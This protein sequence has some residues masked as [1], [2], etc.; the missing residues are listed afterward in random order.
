MTR[1]FIA[2]MVIAAS[3]WGAVCL[4][5]TTDTPSDAAAAP[6]APPAAP[7]AAT[8]AATPAADK[9]DPFPTPK[10]VPLH[11]ELQVEIGK[12]R[13][14]SV[15]LAGQEEDQIFWYLPYTVTNK[16]GED[17]MFVPEIVLYTDSGKLTRA[18]KSVPGAV[19]DRIKALH[20]DPL[21]KAPASMTGK[22]LQGQD[23]AKS[24]VA[25][26]PD[27]DP[28]AGKVSVFIGGLSGETYALTLPAPIT[29]TETDWRGRDRVVTKSA[30]LLTKTLE[31]QFAIP[32]EQPSRKHLKPRMISKRWVMR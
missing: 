25:I 12:L 31:V 30:L 22:L 23:N 9:E 3:G 11:W 27:F 28:N 29:V 13:P 20:S 14:I 21:M 32:G 5:Q 15:R 1:L 10:V 24:S 17:Q 4:A 2:A 19:F 18:G 6:A 8:P 26:W 7:P 16:T